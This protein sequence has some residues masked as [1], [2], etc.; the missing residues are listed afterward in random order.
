MVDF[1]QKK[2]NDKFYGNTVLRKSSKKGYIWVNG[3]FLLTEY[4]YMKRNT[5]L[6]GSDGT[7][8]SSPNVVMIDHLMKYMY[9][10]KVPWYVWGEKARLEYK[11]WIL[12][13][14]DH[15]LVDHN[16]REEMIRKRLI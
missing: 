12:L 5:T 6:K 14:K 16:V 4:E 3:T 10:R 2:L 8:N 15:W 7:A 11:R 1:G 13:R 9:E